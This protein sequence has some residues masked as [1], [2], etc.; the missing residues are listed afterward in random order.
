MINA[1]GVTFDY[2]YLEN[3]YNAGN[4][5]TITLS[6]VNC[7]KACSCPLQASGTLTIKGTG[8]LLIE[9]TESVN[10]C[11]GKKTHTGMSYGRWCPGTDKPLDEIIIDGVSVTLK[12]K[13]PNF[14]L[15]S[16]GGSYVPKITCINDGELICPETTGTRVI[17]KSGAEGLCGSTKRE[18]PAIYEIQKDVLIRNNS[19]QGLD[20]F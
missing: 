8:T 18:A 6:G 1:L 5:A 11:I 4:N 15:G 20:V 13:V 7:I 12:S 10:P 9:C 19:L 16:Y 3:P 17:L 2:T 14:A